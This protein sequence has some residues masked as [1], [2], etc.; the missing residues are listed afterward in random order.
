MSERPDF[1]MVGGQDAGKF[2]LLA[3][4]SLTEVELRM[5]AERP[6]WLN[7]RYML[8]PR[9]RHFVKAEMRDYVVVMADSYSEA[10]RTLFEV[11]SPESGDVA[12]DAGQRELLPGEAL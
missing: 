5:E 4:K 1:V 2:Y 9:E 3:S 12:I 11:W 10:F 7:Y 8:P 6:D